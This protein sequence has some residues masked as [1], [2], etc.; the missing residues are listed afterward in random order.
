[1]DYIDDGGGGGC[2][3]DDVGFLD[4][5]T[6]NGFMEEEFPDRC[7]GETARSG[8]AYELGTS[9]KVRYDADCNVATDYDEIAELGG[10]KRFQ[11]QARFSDPPDP[12]V[13]ECDQD[14][15]VPYQ[16]NVEF[17]VHQTDGTEQSEASL[18]K[19]EPQDSED[20]SDPG[21]NVLGLSLDIVNSVSGVYGSV[22]TTLIDYA[23]S[24]D[25]GSGVT[26]DHR[27]DYTNGGNQEEYYWD[28]PLDGS[29]QDEDDANPHFPDSTDNVAGASI[30]VENGSAEGWTPRLEARSRF[31]FGDLDYYD[32]KCPFDIAASVFKT[33]ETA[34]VS[35]VAEY[36]STAT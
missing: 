31:Q 32:G 8:W 28:I 3:D 1:M 36:T 14:D 15:G 18:S 30:K 33:K 19:P 16:T 4:E 25:S 23:L 29:Y 17:W 22:A 11:M 7:S 12:Y 26:V 13:Q 9:A 20:T 5:D 35:N 10:Y 2:S 6:L 34:I 21:S 27:P 24:S